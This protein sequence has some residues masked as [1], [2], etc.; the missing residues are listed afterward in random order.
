M[1]QPIVENAIEHGMADRPDVGHVTVR[2]TKDGPSLQLEVSDDGP[3]LSGARASAGNGIGLA[4]T[5]ERLARLYGSG[6]GV[7][8]LTVSGGGLTVRL[9][10]PLKLTADG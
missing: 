3:G 6:A 8:T 5:R 10:I 7:E 2:V 9:T 1:L 4:N